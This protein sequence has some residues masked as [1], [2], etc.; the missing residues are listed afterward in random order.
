MSKDRRSEFDPG[1]SKDVEAILMAGDRGH[2]YPN[3]VRINLRMAGMHLDRHVEIDP[4]RISGV[5]DADEEDF[6]PE[7]FDEFEGLTEEEAAELAAAL[8]AEPNDD[9]PEE[10]AYTEEDDS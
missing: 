2:L 10:D 8:D 1:F 9:S 3:E 4:I 5:D 7:D 6:A